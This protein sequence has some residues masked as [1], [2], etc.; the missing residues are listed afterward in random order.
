[1]TMHQKMNV[2]IFLKYIPPKSIFEKKSTLTILLSSLFVKCVKDM[3]CKSSHN[4]SY[5][6]KNERFNLYMFNVIYM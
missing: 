6:K 1:M 4:N 2:L 5:K 3:A